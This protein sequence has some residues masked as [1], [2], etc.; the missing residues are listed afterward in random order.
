MGADGRAGDCIGEYMGECITLTQ[1]WER[2]GRVTDAD[3]LYFCALT[4][5]TVLDGSRFGSLL[6][7]ANHSCEP[8]ARLEAW[9]VQLYRRVAGILTRD[10]KAGEEVTISYNYPQGN[11]LTECWCGAPTCAGWIN[12]LPSRERGEGQSEPSG[13]EMQQVMRGI[14]RGVREHETRKRVLETWATLETWLDSPAWVHMALRSTHGRNVREALIRRGPPFERPLAVKY[15]GRTLDPTKEEEKERD[16]TPVPREDTKSDSDPSLSS[17]KLAAGR[18]R[19]RVCQ[20]GCGS[21]HNARS[22][23]GGQRVG[24][25]THSQ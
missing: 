14:A 17:R 6:R 2:W 19:G 12:R 16:C 20:A 9:G 5:D 7:F 15:G 4:A 11:L 8:N 23:P 3:R 22:C 13:P 10:A 25:P 21:K 1:F 24:S 18:H